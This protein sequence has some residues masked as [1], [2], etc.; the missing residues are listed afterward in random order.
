MDVY[1]CEDFQKVRVNGRLVDSAYAKGPFLAAKD[2]LTFRGYRPISVKDHLG[3]VASKSNS[4]ALNDMASMVA[5]AVRFQQDGL[6]AQL[7][8]EGPLFIGACPWLKTMDEILETKKFQ[9]ALRRG[10]LDLPRLD[11][12]WSSRDGNPEFSRF[13]F[14]ME[15]DQLQHLLGTAGYDGIQFRLTGQGL[16]PPYKETVSQLYF[17][18]QKTPDLKQIE[19]GRRDMDT[20]F[21]SHEYAMDRSSVRIRGIRD[22]KN[23]A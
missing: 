9:E 15:P 8:H 6:P 13:L 1:F 19:I 20:K 23:D 12:W 11:F 16:R 2:E 21:C 17:H 7:L 3:L 22:A 5:E 4:G 18:S 14:D 10:T